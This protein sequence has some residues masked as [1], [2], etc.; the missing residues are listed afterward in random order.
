MP[1]QLSDPNGRPYAG[2]GPTEND[3]GTAVTNPTLAVVGAG[4]DT[5]GPNDGITDSKVATSECS[6]PVMGGRSAGENSGTG[7]AAT[8]LLR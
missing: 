4:T 6:L 8:S 2:G 1:P 5:T 3:D 7:F